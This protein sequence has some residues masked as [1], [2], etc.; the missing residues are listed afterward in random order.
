MLFSNLS[1][2]M[3]AGKDRT[4]N[5]EVFAATDEPHMCHPVPILPI[6]PGTCSRHN[7]NLVITLQAGN[8]LSDGHSRMNTRWLYLIG[9]FVEQETD[10]FQSFQ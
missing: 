7:C 2:T 6:S 8:Q 9:R 1:I 10:V 3:M 4:L 5:S